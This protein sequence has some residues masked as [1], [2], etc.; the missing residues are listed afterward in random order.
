MHALTSLIQSPGLAHASTIAWVVML[1]LVVVLH[2]AVYA[3]P[4]RIVPYNAL[5]WAFRI[6]FNLN[7]D[8]QTVTYATVHDTVP[9]RWSHL[10]MPVEQVAWVVVLFALHPLAL[11]AMLVAV[12]VQ[13][14]QL[15]EP[16]LA[17]G[18]ALLWAL[19]SA[20]GIYALRNWGATAVTAS[21]LLLLAAAP[22][23]VIGHMFEPLP[24][25]VAGA[26]DE[27]LPVRKLRLRPSVLLLLGGG[28]V[29]EFAAAM[30]HRLIIVQAFW[31][32]QQ[33]GYAPRTARD[34][35]A[36]KH[37]GA[38]IREGGW[39]AWGPTGV[40]FAERAGSEAGRG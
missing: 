23:R 10:S 29:S 9:S 16:P 40:L 30:P 25:F 18:L 21:Q 35:T 4:R 33:F 24:P 36:A 7:L 6:D 31:V 17:I 34:W 5:P 22:V 11:V 32:A 38:A 14:R 19:F 37:L 28:V 3:A 39:K 26:G 20:L 13:A 8:F 15:R 2:I 12:A 1:A 27:F